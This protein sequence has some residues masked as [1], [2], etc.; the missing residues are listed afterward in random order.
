MPS[1]LQNFD[2]MGSDLLESEVESQGKRKDV[3]GV[4][5]L[6]EIEKVEGEEKKAKGSPRRKREEKAT[7]SIKVRTSSVPQPH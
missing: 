7:Q 3:E 4:E 5:T 2:D 1:P 6:R